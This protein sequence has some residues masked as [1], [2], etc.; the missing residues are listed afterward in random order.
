M[1][2]KHTDLYRSQV[3]KTNGSKIVVFFVCPFGTRIWMTRHIVQKLQRSGYSVVAYDA[4]KDVFTA[5]NPSLLK[6]IVDGVKYG[7][8]KHIE[9]FKKEGI[10]EFGFFGTSLGAFILYNCINDCKDLKWGVLNT[11]GNAAQA[12]WK[13]KAIRKKHEAKGITLSALEK[14][15]Y[16][17]QHPVFS[18]LSGHTYAFVSSKGDRLAPLSDIRQYL[19]PIREAGANIGIIEIKAAG[20]MHA[21]ITGLVQAASLLSR[22]RSGDVGRDL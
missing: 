11:G 2:Q 19:L 16:G 13:M 3:F 5:A 8:K 9:T 17:L 15:W 1:T 22:V 14:Q 18:G 10:E 7:I 6:E 4:S 21:A 12:I 20:H